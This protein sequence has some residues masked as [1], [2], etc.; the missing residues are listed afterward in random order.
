MK[1]LSTKLVNWCCRKQFNLRLEQLLIPA[2]AE[3]A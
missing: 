2:Q 1:V 3:E